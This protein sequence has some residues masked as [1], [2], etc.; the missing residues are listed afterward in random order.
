MKFFD[1][2]LRGYALAWDETSLDCARSGPPRYECIPRGA[3]VVSPNLYFDQSHLGR[4]NAFAFSHDGS[5]RAWQDDYGLAFEVA[6]PLT[7]AGANVHNALRNG[8]RLGVSVEMDGLEYEPNLRNGV[9]VVRRA[10]VSAISIMGVGRAHYPQA[11]C[12]LSSSGPDHLAP[13]L[14]DARRRWSAPIARHAQASVRAKPLFDLALFSQLPA[15][16]R[17]VA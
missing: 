5:A 13:D 10:E 6:L 3:L 4:V 1:A 2:R 9:H 8:L 7:F 16:R 11:C 17:R 15:P 14:E 12:W